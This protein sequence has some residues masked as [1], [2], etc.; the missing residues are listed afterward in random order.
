MAHFVEILHSDGDF[1]QR[2]DYLNDHDANALTKAGFVINYESVDSY[3]DGE[4]LEWLQ[5]VID[6]QG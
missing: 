4:L 3:E 2:I 1:V 5:E 6:R